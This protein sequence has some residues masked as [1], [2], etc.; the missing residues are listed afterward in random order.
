ML[1]PHCV[2]YVECSSLPGKDTLRNRHQAVTRTLAFTLSIYS[3]VACQ[4]RRHR[5]PDL[6]GHCEI[7][8]YFRSR[9]A[10]GRQS[11]ILETRRL[12]SK[13][14]GSHCKPIPELSTSPDPQDPQLAKTY[15]LM[16]RKGRNNR[17]E[18]P[19]AH[20]GV[21]A[22]SAWAPLCLHP[23]SLLAFTS[24]CYPSKEN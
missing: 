10:Q 1:A 3:E 6:C 18:S 16:G 17:K 21:P 2:K 13:D 23:V 19:H 22:C 9:K 15:I 7:P 5:S 14:Q 8:R 4:Q 24:F 20:R 12:K 11:L